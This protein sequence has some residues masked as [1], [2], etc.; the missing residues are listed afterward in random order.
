M[1]IV[2]AKDAAHSP[3]PATQAAVLPSAASHAAPAP[4]EAVATLKVLSAQAAPHVD[5]TPA[6]SMSRAHSPASKELWPDSH[7]AEVQSAG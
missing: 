1:T 4:D 5:Q 2:D 7:V 3:S 6:Q